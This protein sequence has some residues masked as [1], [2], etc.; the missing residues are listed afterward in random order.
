MRACGNPGSTGRCIAAALVLCAAVARGG[1]PEPVGPAT[2]EALA[3]CRESDQVSPA[4][5]WVVLAR[6]LDR[7][8]EAVRA[9]PQDAAAHFAVFCTLGKRLRMKWRDEGLFAALGELGRVQREI[10]TALAL[11][12]DY[13]PA[14]AAKGEMLVEL[15]RLLGGD[16]REGERLLRRAVAL[17]PDDPQMRLMLANALRS[18]G[19][20]DQALAHA[21]IALG[22]LEHAGSA[23]ELADARGLVA[24]L[25]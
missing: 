7:A 19:Q 9:D 4:E 6:G 1:Q 2:T 12:P 5:R 8:E 23:S 11:E 15:P 25:R 22:I 14:L 20:R 16:P 10:D 3:L 21:S 18:A 24:S 17:D 13:A